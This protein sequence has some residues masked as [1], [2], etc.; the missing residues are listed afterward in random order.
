MKINAYHYRMIAVYGFAYINNG[1]A[2]TIA[3]VLAIKE[4]LSEY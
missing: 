1:R 3:F 4:C 2:L